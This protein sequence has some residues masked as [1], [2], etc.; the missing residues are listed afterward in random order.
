MVNTPPTRTKSAD[1]ILDQV[2]EIL[3]ANAAGNAQLATNFSDFVRDV[4]REINRGQRVDAAEL[5]SRWIDFNL[6]SYSLL[7]KQSLALLD[8]L[9]AVARET[10]LPSTSRPAGPGQR[11]ELRMSGRVGERVTTSFVIENQ[12]D[13][14]LDV[15]FECDDLLSTSGQKQPA[16]LVDFTPPKLS[17]PPRNQAVG[18][19]GVTLKGDFA[20]GESYR[21]TIRLLGF[22]G[23][24]LGLLL[25]VLAAAE[26]PAIAPSPSGSQ[27]TPKAPRSSSRAPRSAPQSG[28]KATL[29]APRARRTSRRRSQSPG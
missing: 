8:G 4:S 17:I 6:Q 28:S 16:A 22:A 18:Q 27:A 25:N 24:E 10:L 2:R 23:K 21:T 20:V 29:T 15:G 26:K 5:F 11:V 13:Q 1:E 12:F 3:A 19:V 9:L 7:N 14:P